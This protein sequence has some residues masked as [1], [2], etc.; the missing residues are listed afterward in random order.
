MPG[1]EL[2]AWVGEGEPVRES[3]G[4]TQPKHC[5]FVLSHVSATLTLFSVRLPPP[6]KYVLS[7]AFP[8]APV[9]V[10]AKA[11]LKVRGDVF[12]SGD[13]PG[14]GTRGYRRASLGQ[15]WRCINSDLVGLTQ[16]YDSSQIPEIY[17]R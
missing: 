16:M 11:V 2:P 3:R 14:L 1:G 10:S 9:Q 6:C 8:L 15:A 17:G 13:R 4:P 5:H 12:S 7:V